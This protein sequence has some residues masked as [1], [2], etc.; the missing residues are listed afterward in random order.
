MPD[1]SFAELSIQECAGRAFG[2]SIGNLFLGVF[3]MVWIVIGLVSVRPMNLPGITLSTEKGSLLVL[4]LLGSCLAILIAASIYVM[5][6]T[7]GLLDH[8]EENRAR[9]KRINRWF[10]LIN[11]VQWALI[12][13]A[14]FGLGRLGLGE[15]IVP[16]IMLVVGIHFFPLAWLF[17]NRM[18]YV[19]GLAIV[20]WAIV[21]PILFSVAR[22]NWIGSVGMGVILWIGAACMCRQAFQL[23]RRTQLPGSAQELHHA[24]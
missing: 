7:H 6:R 4:A 15:W 11:L 24:V 14:V 2:M 16:A 19:T 10:G 18:H 3:G 9:G 5:R 17:E 13:A 21:Y 1:R 22:G 23:L 12:V 8:S 20:A